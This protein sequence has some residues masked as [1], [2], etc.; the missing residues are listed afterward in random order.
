MTAKELDTMVNAIKTRHNNVESRM[1]LMDS[2]YY[3]HKGLCAIKR[4]D[5]AKK[6]EE[7]YEE[8]DGIETS[9]IVKMGTFK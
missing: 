5:L 2:I 7:L 3:L 8:I 9:E 6:L 1:E 4:N